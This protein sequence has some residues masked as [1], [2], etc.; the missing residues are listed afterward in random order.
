LTIFQTA[1]RWPESITLLDPGAHN[2]MR[3][4]PACCYASGHL[5]GL[6]NRTTVLS[7]PVEEFQATSRRQYDTVVS[8]NFI[9]HV[10]DTIQAY[11]TVVRSFLARYT[12][13]EPAGMQE[14]DL[15]PIR[16]TNCFAHAFAMEFKLL[17]ETERPEQWGNSGYYY[18]IGR[19]R[20]FVMAVPT[21]RHHRALEVS[22]FTINKIWGNIFNGDDM[23]QSQEYM[24]YTLNLHVCTVCKV[25]FAGGHSAVVY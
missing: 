22:D 19:R 15:H 24:S 21:K 20:S 9:K 16:L 2:Y 3:N 8:I 23:E 10:Q 5:P 17:Y 12:G 11:R 1:Q 25:G 13:V 14:F 18:F 4:V 7:I 6:E